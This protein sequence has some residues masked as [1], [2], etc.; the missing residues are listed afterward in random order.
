MSRV[1]GHMGIFSQQIAK[2]ESEVRERK[3]TLV[4][5][6]DGQVRRV[7]AVVAMSIMAPDGR[8]FA[9]VGKCRG[10]RWRA[11]CMLPGSKMEEGE[12]PGDTLQRL[13][14]TA[15][16]PFAYSISLEHAEQTTEW[17][18]SESSSL[19]TKYIRN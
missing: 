7:A 8:I 10:E 2:L 9:Q 13:L 4:V 18:F 6:E 19:Q 3:C 15:L 14:R 16:S 17:K 11:C 1:W 12:L 5:T